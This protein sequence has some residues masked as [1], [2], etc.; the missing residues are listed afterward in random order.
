MGDVHGSEF[1]PKDLQTSSIHSDKQVHGLGKVFCTE[2]AHREPTFLGNWAEEE[3]Q[4]R[5][6]TKGLKTLP[7]TQ[8]ATILWKG[9]P[10]AYLTKIQQKRACLQIPA[11]SLHYKMR[12]MQTQ[13]RVP[14]IRPAV[15]L[16]P[17]L[18]RCFSPMRTLR[19]SLI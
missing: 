12:Y 1:D 2:R 11:E 16:G 6:I 3:T 9:A 10:P 14:C 7:I 5:S 13:Y 4:H 19:R 18:S 8:T 15:L 17:L